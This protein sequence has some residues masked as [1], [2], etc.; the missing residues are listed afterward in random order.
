MKLTLIEHD[1]KIGN[2]WLNNASTWCKIVKNCNIIDLKITEKSE[3]Y[4]KYSIM[5]FKQ[6]VLYSLIYS[7]IFASCLIDILAEIS[8]GICYLCKPGIINLIKY[9]SNHTKN[10]AIFLPI[11]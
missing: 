10:T 3:K 8:I 6:N 2:K 11:L 1:I 7:R 5:M 9:K 4:Q